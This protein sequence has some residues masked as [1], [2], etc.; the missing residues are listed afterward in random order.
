MQRVQEVLIQN[1]E[2]TK[3]L[4][5]KLAK[6]LKPGS[7]VALFGDLGTG[8]TTLTKAIGLS[9]GVTEIIT[10]PTFTV[11]HEYRNGVLPLYHFDAYRL[12][13][14]KELLDFGYEEYFY[15]QGVTIIEWADRIEGFLPPETISIHM[16]YGETE[17]QRRYLIQGLDE[18]ELCGF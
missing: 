7:I 9:L 3:R 4:G 14:E 13:N 2:G 6:H 12:Q 18:V 8:K 15:G 16:Y 5:Q 11:I 1:E 10:S 17:N